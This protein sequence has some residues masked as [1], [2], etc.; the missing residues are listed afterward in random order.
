MILDTDLAAFLGGDAA[1][2]VSAQQGTDAW[3]QQRCGLITASRIGDLMA[4]TKSGPS[5]SR[6]N[7]IA[8]LV[9]ERLTGTVE[10]SYTN[11]AMQHGTENEPLARAAY[12]ALTGE[13]VQEV[14]LIPHPY[15]KGAGASPDGLVGDDG[16]IEIKCPN[17]ATHI[18]TLLG[19]PIDRKY[20]LQMQ[21]Q[22]CCTDRAWCDFAS[23]D[24]R[25]PEHLQLHVRRVLRDLAQ[26]RE[27]EGEVSAALLEIETTIS[28]LEALKE[29]APDHAGDNLDGLKAELLGDKPAP[30]MDEIIALIPA[31]KQVLVLPPNA[32]SSADRVAIP[33][34][35]RVGLDGAP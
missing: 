28:K 22:M 7:Y 10:A 24:N 2:A 26:Q 31:E 6:A 30:T 1:P 14:G 13:L 8:Q 5:A 15:I 4:K 35:R 32:S 9:C 12:E 17:S 3:R 18:E 16:L 23:F 25:L 20:L 19:A 11:A 29:A 33:L 21:W 27:I 34:Q